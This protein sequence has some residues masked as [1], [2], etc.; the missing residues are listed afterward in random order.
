MRLCHSVSG[1]GPALCASREQTR[2]VRRQRPVVARVEATLGLRLRETGPLGDG[3]M[4]M[5]MFTMCMLLMTIMVDRKGDTP[6][7]ADAEHQTGSP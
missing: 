6:V 1:R 3:L 4:A 7:M 2:A 5:L